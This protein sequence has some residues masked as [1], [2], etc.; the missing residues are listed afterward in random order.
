[1]EARIKITT[2]QG[3]WPA[4]WMLPTDEIYGGWPQSGEI[5]IMENIGSEPKTV[6]GTIHFGQ[7]YP[8]NQSLGASSKLS[9]DPAAT[10]IYAD[11]FPHL[12]RRA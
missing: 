9:Y 7:P 2:T 6:H 3:I 11:G 10:E 5:D 4:F 8:N 1:M 12:R